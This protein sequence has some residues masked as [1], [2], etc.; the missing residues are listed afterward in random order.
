MKIEDFIK[1]LEEMGYTVMTVKDEDKK[2]EVVSLEDAKAIK[3]AEGD[4]YFEQV[5]KQN[6]ERK[7][8]QKQEREQSNKKVIRSY[9]LK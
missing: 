4:D 1:E 2:S 8:K 5:R 9:R 7:R 3:E 6:A